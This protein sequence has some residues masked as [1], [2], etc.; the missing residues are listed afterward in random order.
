MA[1]GIGKGGILVERCEPSWLAIFAASLKQQ[2]CI[3]FKEQRSEIIV[4][5][6]TVEKVLSFISLVAIVLTRRVRS[7]SD[8]IYKQK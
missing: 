5:V 2:A 7:L 3:L 8:A 1:R 4:S 6:T